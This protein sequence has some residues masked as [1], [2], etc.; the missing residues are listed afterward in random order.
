LT[1]VLAEKRVA[2]GRCSRCDHDLEVTANRVGS[3]DVRAMRVPG[4]VYCSNNTCPYYAEE[5]HPTGNSENLGLE[6]T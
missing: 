6:V 4:M 5:P 2:M 3:D 1:R